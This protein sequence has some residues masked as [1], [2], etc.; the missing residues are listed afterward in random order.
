MRGLVG[1]DFSAFER[2]RSPRALLPALVALFVAAFALVALRT[3]VLKLRYELGQR[4]EQERVLDAR[5]RDLT[6]RMRRLRE[7]RALAE[8][9]AELGFGRPERVIDLPAGPADPSAQLAR[10]DEAVEVQP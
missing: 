7:P 9:A 4:L 5:Q 1:R 10:A 8:R 6:V 2:R 3:E